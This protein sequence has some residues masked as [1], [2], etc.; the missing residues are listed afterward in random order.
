MT[1]VIRWCW[2]RHGSRKSFLLN[3]I[4]AHAQKYDPFTVICRPRWQLYE[5]HTDTWR[6]CVADGAGTPGLQHQPILL[7]A[8]AREPSLLAA[9][10]RV[11]AQSGGQHRV[12]MQETGD[13]DAVDNI[14]A[15]SP[16]SAGCSHSRTSC[17]ERFAALQRWVTRRPL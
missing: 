12:T 15:L 2:V 13:L 10:V 17:H 9:L 6:Q 14:Y 4:L 7:A 5:A 3:F 16:A 1:S 11:L 8:D